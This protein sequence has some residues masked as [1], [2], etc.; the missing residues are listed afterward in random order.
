VRADIIT[1]SE[2]QA[3]QVVDSANS[4]LALVRSIGRMIKTKGPDHDVKE[5]F[6]SIQ[7]EQ[8]E[9]VAVF[10]ATI[11]Q[12]ILEKIWSEAKAE[13]AVPTPPVRKP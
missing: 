9:N 13:G 2:A 4:H 7:A 3:K 6:D 10:T 1:Q 11:P 12:S 8:K 5:A